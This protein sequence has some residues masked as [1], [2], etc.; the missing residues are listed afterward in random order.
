MVFCIFLLNEKQLEEFNK[1]LESL[2]RKQNDT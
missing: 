1:E 2:E